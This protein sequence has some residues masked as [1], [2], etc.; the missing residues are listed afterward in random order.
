MSA[1]RG[2]C[3]VI[4]LVGCCLLLFV[5]R[6]PGPV[7]RCIGLGSCLPA[8]RT[9][10][11]AGLWLVAPRCCCCCCCCCC[12]LWAV[13]VS[14][15]VRRRP[16]SCPS[17]PEGRHTSKRVPLSEART[18]PV[19]GCFFPCILLIRGGFA[20]SLSGCMAVK[21]PLA[22][23]RRLSLVGGKAVCSWRVGFFCA[24]APM[25]RGFVCSL[26]VPPLFAFFSSTWLGLL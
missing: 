10:V 22:F 23:A 26:W 15:S 6:L 14:L 19:L 21:G 17:L 5:V 11:F 12:L 9:G 16:R 2:C 20:G 7:L 13:V 4:C 18:C 3:V 8:R 25:A 1:L 24:C